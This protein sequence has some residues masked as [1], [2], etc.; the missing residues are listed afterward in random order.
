M[1]KIKIAEDFSAT[2]GARYY[3]DGPASGQE[4]FEKI[5]KD[6]FESAISNNQKLTIDLDGTDGYASSFLNEAFRRLSSAYDAET[7]WN[8]LVL[9]SNEIPKYI[10]KIKKS[11]Y[12]AK[13]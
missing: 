11:I 7:V 6:K 4:F 3:E 5:L 9:I 12:D 13:K 10:Q 2:P 1:F 8:N